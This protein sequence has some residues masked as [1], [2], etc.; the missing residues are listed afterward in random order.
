MTSNYEELFDVDS[1]G[2]IPKTMDNF[3]RFGI[4]FS[5]DPDAKSITHSVYSV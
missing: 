2:K 4:S 1:T 3:T 5:I